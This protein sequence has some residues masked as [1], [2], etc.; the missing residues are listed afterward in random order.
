LQCGSIPTDVYLL[1]DTTGS[2][3]SYLAAVSSGALQIINSLSAN[4]TDIAFGAGDYKD[5]VDPYAFKN[6]A[7]ITADGGVAARAAINAWDANGGDD[8]PEEQLFALWQ[9]RLDA[10]HVLA[11]H[12]PACLCCGGTPNVLLPVALAVTSLQAHQPT[13]LPA[14]Q[15][16]CCRPAYFHTPDTFPPPST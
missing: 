2:M 4:I 10:A 12:L 16:A 7:P 14:C 8:N 5:F 11:R 15:P 13:S 6:A 1:A 3:A 9:V